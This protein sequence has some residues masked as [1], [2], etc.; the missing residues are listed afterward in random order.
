VRRN[1]RNAM[2]RLTMSDTRITAWDGIDVMKHVKDRPEAQIMCDW[3]Y[4]G[5]YRNESKLYKNEMASL[6]MHIKGADVLKECKAAVVMCGYRSPREDIPTIYDAILTGEEWHCFKLADTY[7]KPKVVKPGE[8]KD[9][10]FEYVWTNR[11][12]KNAGLYLSMQDYKEKLSFDEYWE[13]IR[14][15]YADGK[16][17]K[18]EIREYEHA[19]SSYFEGK[20][21]FPD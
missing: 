5:I 10:A 16:L 7:C 13:R 21:L 15:A 19:Y 14:K 3:P 9:K 12:P 11:M 2:E 4:V 17:E 8:K 6:Y 1:L 18:K 20:K